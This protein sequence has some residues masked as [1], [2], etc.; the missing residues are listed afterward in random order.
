[1]HLEPEELALYLKGQLSLDSLPSLESHLAACETCVQ[2]MCE[3]DRYLWCLA[4]ISGDE[5]A[6]DGDRRHSLRVATDQAASVQSLSP[7]SIDAWDV[8]V[9]DV[10]KGGV[11][12]FTPRPLAFESLVRIKMKF[13]VACGD[14]RY[15][16]PG[17]G[18][19]Y[20]GIRLHDYFLASTARSF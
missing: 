6:P 17:E 7:F 14:V 1:M 15:C 4:E 10:S 11:R 12:I 9:V 13:T 3:Q 19:H 20:A 8:R 16:S 5:L 2:T 18:G